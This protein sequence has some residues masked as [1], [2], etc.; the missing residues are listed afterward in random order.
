MRLQAF[1]DAGWRNLRHASR[2]LLRT[3]GFTFIAVVTLA[4]GIGATSA[5]LSAVDAILLR[6]LP[7]PDSHQLMRLSQASDIS[8]NIVIA[9]VR[10]E[11]WN[12]LNSSF[13]AMSGWYTEDASGTSGDLPE[14]FRLAS[15]AP[16]FLDVWGIGPAIGR[17]FSE[18]D[19]RFGSEP[20]ALI[21]DR[22]WRT[23]L[24][25][26]PDVLGR[27]LRTGSRGTFQ[28]VGVMPPSFLFHERDVDVWVPVP[29]NAPFAQS[30]FATWF[31]GIGRLRPGVTLE[32]ARDNIEAVQR[33]LAAQFPESD[34]KIRPDVVPLKASTVER[35]Q[36]SL[37][38]MSAAVIVLLFIACT[39]V[40]ALLLARV[41][42]RRQEISVRISLG[43]S[44][45]SIAAQLLTETFV[46][47]AAG[48]LAGL[49]VLWTLSGTLAALAASF[50]RADEI[51]LDWRV[52][53]YTLATTAIVTLLCGSVPA[54]RT[55]RDGIANPLAE[56]GRAQLSGSAS[57]QWL[58][59]GLQVTLSVTL[60][61]AAGLLLRSFSELARVDPGFDPSHVVSF[62]ISGSY[63]E[64]V[65]FRRVMQRIERTLDE[66][67]GV[68]GVEAVAV[69]AALPGVPQQY[70]AEFELAEG[71]AATE[72]PMIAESRFVS[73]SYFATLHIPL[74]AGTLC[75]NQATEGIR[76]LMVNRRFAE[77]YLGGNSAVGHVLTPPA[78]TA[79]LPGVPRSGRIAG[80]VGDA[81]ERGIDRDPV[82]TVY[83]CS[84]AA[85][86]MPYYLVRA[87]LNAAAIVQPVRLKIK[88]IEPLRS[89]FDIAPLETRIGDAF[90]ENRLRTLLLTLFA[91]TA[92]SLASVGLYGTLSYAVSLR[93]REVGLRMALGA[94]R[95][96]ILRQFLSRGLRV[97]GVGA[98][99]GLTLSFAVGRAVSSL[100]FGV[101]PYD[102][103]TLA[104]VLLL[105]LAVAALASLLPSARAAGV[106]PMQVL[107][108]E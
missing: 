49:A 1:V 88:D 64:S 81:R 9:P 43:A 95:F 62:R 67:G 101:S 70:E 66:L 72:P 60:L 11:D 13:T 28:I 85:N 65:D 25:N 33:Q 106:E 34:G 90:A 18:A 58:L 29:I 57:L 22:Y 6:P 16:R 96:D 8:P 45:T 21:S 12:R 73:D 7:F 71:R 55:A 39:N 82:P 48:A 86:P 80:I 14:P 3:P 68:A 36:A 52:L 26:S 83:W 69:S 104:G 38:L 44:R 100:L 24:A 79:T 17:G 30:R 98:A 47:S 15:V 10:L 41:A 93:R 99:L 108:D 76:D 54:W 5:V 42:S 84:T 31:N 61:V 53:L 75:R 37:W 19:H 59:V 94:E 35:V 107:R 32:Q 4:L 89:V 92:L 27:Y 56:A 63:A 74:V 40:A 23:R 91:G 50:P 97:V 105:V 2:A 20:I 77:Q 46:L 87:T 102:P 78:S 103:L 51:G